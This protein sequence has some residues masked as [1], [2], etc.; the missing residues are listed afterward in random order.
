[1]IQHLSIDDIRTALSLPPVTSFSLDGEYE[2][3]RQAAVLVPFVQ[4]A[5]EWSLLFI[6]R[7]VHE[8]DHHSGQVAFAG[9]KCED[10]DGSMQATAL[11]E[12]EE[13][14]G[15]NPADVTVLGELGK[16]VSGAG[17]EI[18][19]VVA[20]MP[21]P[22]SLTLSADEVAAT[23]TMPLAWLA[24]PD[25]VEHRLY[26]ERFNVPYFE[27]YNDHLLWGATA[28][29]ALSLIEQLQHAHPTILPGSNS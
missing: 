21:W 12:A 4:E 16:H 15:L 3:P 27:R 14:I 11:R 19:P 9:G 8:R 26:K 1:M 17:F 7:A 13:E 23:F 2:N 10:D 25:N 24:D 18:C 28:R 6:E 29:I 20:T 5:E 22:Y